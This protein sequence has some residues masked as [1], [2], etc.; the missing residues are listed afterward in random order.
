MTALVLPPSQHIF[1]TDGASVSV[2]MCLNAMIRHE[3]DAVLVPIPQYP[4]YSASIRLYGKQPCM[5]RPCRPLPP[6]RANGGEPSTCA[7]RYCSAST[8]LTNAQR[9]AP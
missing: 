7:P 1:L 2:R 6:Q 9:S 3:R 4:L 5:H 8:T